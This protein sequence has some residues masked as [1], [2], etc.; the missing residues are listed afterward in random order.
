M[1]IEKL[2]SNLKRKG[3]KP[4]FFENKESAVQFVL[5]LIPNQASVGFGGSMTVK[6]LALDFALAYG[7]KKIVSVLGVNK[8]SSDLEDR[9]S[10]GKGKIVNQRV[11]M[12]GGR[13]S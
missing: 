6:E 7:V 4:Y 11:L 10:V 12:G 13:I 8:I 9:K 1:Q 2:T 3:F 5:D